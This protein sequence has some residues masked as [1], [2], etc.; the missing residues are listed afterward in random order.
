M[1]RCNDENSTEGEV[2]A[3]MGRFFAFDPERFPYAGETLVI[4]EKHNLSHV[5]YDG[6]TGL[7][8]W[9]GAVLLARYMEK[10]PQIVMNKRVLELGAGCGLVG[11]AAAKL[12]A[13][14]VVMTDL[15]YAL[16]LM[17]ENVEHNTSNDTHQ[18]ISCQECDWSKP[19]TLNEL[20]QSSNDGKSEIFPDV[21]IVADCVW[22]SALVAP[23][24]RTL[25][26]YTSNSSTSVIISYQQRVR[27]L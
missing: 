14:D 11:I 22:L 4:K 8:V 12:G 13:K 7:N 21:I 10:R 16:P 26:A 25:K 5:G 20:F 6:G 15:Q 9:D 17:R 23:L 18:K 24:L 1:S 19:P 27:K 3:I 2:L